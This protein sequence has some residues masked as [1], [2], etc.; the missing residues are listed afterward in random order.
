MAMKILDDIGSFLG[1]TQN[2]QMFR[3]IGESIAT[4]KNHM[5]TNDWIT[6]GGDIM[7]VAVSIATAGVGGAAADEAVAGAEMVGEHAAEEGGE[8]AT[9]D[10]G[11]RLS[12][13]ISMKWRDTEMDVEKDIVPTVRSEVKPA[14]KAVNKE[15]EAVASKSW[16]R[17]KINTFKSWIQERAERGRI[18]NVMDTIGPEKKEL[19]DA[20]ER[21]DDPEEIESISKD[22][23]AKLYRMVKKSDL[24]RGKGDAL[25]ALRA[26]WENGQKIV[27]DVR[28]RS[29]DVKPTGR[30]VE[31]YDRSMNVFTRSSERFDDAIRPYK[32]II[33]PLFITHMTV[34]LETG[35]E[36]VVNNPAPLSFL[37]F[38]QDVE[39]FG[40]NVGVGLIE[41]PA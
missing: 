36:K 33:K 5:S 31:A 30:F 38:G 15:G 26:R 17:Q 9:I 39:S 14:L 24:P 25:D 23:D 4:G 19:L 29:W 20:I 7:I 1:I 27:N 2:V 3:D 32:P 22:L 37:Q 35:L 28:P 41:D 40:E 12:G 11:S 10:E 6:L 18:Q 13:S 34:T 8:R 21:D 16:M